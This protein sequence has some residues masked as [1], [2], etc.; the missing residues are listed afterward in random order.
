MENSC[1]VEHMDDDISPQAA[2]RVAEAAR[3]A[4]AARAMPAW[5]PAVTAALFAACLTGVGSA[6]LIGWH[7]TAAKVVGL[8]GTACGLALGLM[9]A[10]LIAG[11]IRSGVIPL[12]RSCAKPR[13]DLPDLWIFAGVLAVSAAA[14]AV[15]GR[16][17]WGIIV[18][19]ITEGVHHWRRLLP[20][21]FGPALPGTRR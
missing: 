19:G 16:P 5:F 3:T 21:L 1:Y 7:D 6:Q 9:Y 18:F 20:R 11:W 10:A 4:A 15:G 12:P 13:S 17:G 8:A 2:V 14:W